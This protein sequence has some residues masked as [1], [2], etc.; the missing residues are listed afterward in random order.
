M[1]LISLTFCLSTLIVFGQGNPANP[2]FDEHIEFVLENVDLSDV[3][4]GV[5]YECGFPWAQFDIYSG[6]LYP[7]NASTYTAFSLLY[8][9]LFDMAIDDQYRLPNP[10]TYRSK[11]DNYEEGGAIPLAVL[12]YEYYQFKADAIDNNLIYEQNGQLF[13]V[14]GASTS[15]FDKKESFIIAPAVNTI[16]SAQLK[17]VFDSDLYF[18]NHNKTIT[19]LAIDM[20]DGRGWIT[21]NFGV[22]VIA[23][24]EDDAIHDIRYRITYADGTIYYGHSIFDI[25][26]PT[27]GTRYAENVIDVD[28][29]KHLVAEDGYTVYDPGHPDHGTVKYSGGTVYISYACGHDE[30][31]K[32]FIWVEGYNP[33]VGTFD[34]SLNYEDAIDRIQLGE[35]NQLTLEQYLE[36]EGYDLVVIDF[37]DSRT[38][39]QNNANFLR[40]ALKWINEQKAL[41]CSSEKNVLLGQSYGGM[42]SRFCLR[43]MELDGLNHEVNKFVAFDMG[44]QGVNVPLGFQY[45][46]KHLAYIP[47]NGITLSQFVA[48]IDDLRKVLDLPSSRQM[49]IYQTDEVWNENDNEWQPSN[50]QSLHDYYYH[51]QNQV[52]GMPTQCEVYAIANG[53]KTGTS[54]GHGFASGDEMLKVVGKVFFMLDILQSLPVD[55]SVNSPLPGN[56]PLSAISDYID[57]FNITTINA[58]PHLPTNDLPIYDG[59]YFISLFNL[60]IPYSHATKDVGAGI[61]G[62]DAAPGSFPKAA[63]NI[64]TI[65]APEAIIDIKFNSFGFI[66]LTSSLNYQNG[67]GL[68]DP[69]RS[70]LINQVELNAGNVKD[71]DSYEGFTGIYNPSGEN[72]IGN[73]I[74]GGLNNS[75]HTFFNTNNVPFLLFHLVGENQLDGVNAIVNETYHFAEQNLNSSYNYPTPVPRRVSSILD[76]TM[77][78]VNNSTLAINS[79][80]S[81]VGFNSAGLP[82]I[83]S[84]Y[85]VEIRNACDETDPITLY[86]QS[87]SDMI[88][89]DDN[90]RRGH[91]RVYP[92]HSVI[93]RDGATLEIG[94]GSTVIMEENS[95]LK[96]ENNGTILAHSDSKII[97]KAGSSLILE[98]GGTIINS[99][100]IIMKGIPDNNDPALNATFTYLNGCTFRMADDDAELIF[101]GGDLFVGDNATFTFEHS[102]FNESGQLTF[103]DFIYGPSID[104][105]VNSK[106]VINGK[107]GDDVILELKE[108]ADFWT[109]DN[110]DY[111]LI[112]NG[113]T[114]LDDDARFV[115]IPELFSSGVTYTGLEGNRG[116]RIFDATHISNCTFNN[117]QVDAPLFYKNSGTLLAVNSTFTDLTGDF[118][119]KVVGKGYTV[120]GCTF[121]SE[122]LAMIRSHS[123]TEFSQIRNCELNGNNQNGSVDFGVYDYSNAEIQMSN[124]NLND[125]GVGISKYDGRLN[126]RCNEFKDFYLAGVVASSNCW[127]EMSNSS[128]N[129]YNNFKKSTSGFGNN[130]KLNCAQYMQVKFGRNAFDDV[131]NLDIIEGSVQ[132]G[133]PQTAKQYLHC[134][135]NQWRLNDPNYIPPDSRFNITSC[136]TGNN[137]GFS[138]VDPEV[139]A[140]GA[141][142]PP[143]TGINSPVGVGGLNGSKKVNTPH[144]N[145]VKI[146]DAINFT[147]KETERVNDQKNDL[148]ALELF[149]EI[150]TYDFNNPNHQTRWLI[151]FGFDYMKHTMIHCFT[152]GKTSRAANASGF[153]TCVQRYVNVLNHLTEDDISDN[154]YERMFYLEMDK[155]HLFHMIGKYDIAIDLLKNMELCGL[156]YDEQ[157]HVNEWKYLLETEQAKFNYGIEAEFKDTIWVDTSNYFVPTH[158]PFGNFGSTIVDHGT[159]IYYNCFNPKSPYG[160]DN[161][162]ELSV[163]PNPTE[164]VVN[165]TYTVPEEVQGEII[166][167]SVDGKLI[168]R[169]VCLAGKH[170]QSVDLS[171]IPTGV[172]ILELRLDG[173]IV[174]SKKVVKN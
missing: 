153:E 87:G 16:N 111:I 77:V 147:L 35:L 123:L 8:A 54:G 162:I 70:F 136:I 160:K 133:P 67:L 80:L 23:N 152:T 14:T 24:Y 59:H 60:T 81:Q 27:G 151:Q 156:D 108:S 40:T 104:G 154:N 167:T 112:S 138:V 115:A 158:Q 173:M 58:I 131:G 47:I 82:N 95:V 142:D 66:P 90:T 57:G 22:P 88:L 9:S 34:W 103:E 145:N 128:S 166:I 93:V 73:P 42:I 26:I 17:L 165:I 46:T 161:E 32:P 36:Q 37:D 99:G 10:T 122:T 56:T 132:I 92:G 76:H 43:S 134:H 5:L 78:V 48:P 55:L 96:V 62:F 20:D 121:N 110:F 98:G 106:I 159:V 7:N 12:H 50:V 172:Y 171:K 51:Q 155:V 65:V 19:D 45:M 94:K 120:S 129:G 31:I 38:Y 125:C 52:L 63:I 169:F 146:N 113:K 143:I 69:Y 1:K 174:D 130:I 135:K 97:L 83:N 170:I 148:Y 39:I 107:N 18:F 119:I 71:I 140:C 41:A 29:V 85:T 3:D 168:Q 91:L 144:F 124:N 74:P 150:L 163:Y 75:T 116:V 164:N 11:M 79:N 139:D 157:K 33:K 118:N 13:D 21:T 109:T 84:D 30:L 137:L 15:P 127:L 4:N 102:G 72:L 61:V 126:L 86:V 117:V 101:E 28:V 6:Q 68:Y 100:D 114:T 149:E 49:M 2:S 64:P 44:H 105:G 53:A 141:N 89:G 25:K